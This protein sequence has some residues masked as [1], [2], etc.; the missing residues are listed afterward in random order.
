MQ[1][2]TILW[3]QGICCCC[4]GPIAAVGTFLPWIL[5]WI[6]FCDRYIAVADTLPQWI[7]CCGGYIV[8]INTLLWWVHCSNDY[9]A[10]VG[11]LLQWIHCCS[12]YIA[13]VD[14]LLQYPYRPEMESAKPKGIFQRNEGRIPCHYLSQQGYF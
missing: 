10:T 12:G 1:S 4:S 7:R 8:A 5:P 3:L 13:A 11:T 9:I 2:F 14:T 6:H